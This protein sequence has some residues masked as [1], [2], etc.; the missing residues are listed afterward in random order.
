MKGTSNIFL[1][2]IFIKNSIERDLILVAILHQ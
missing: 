2:F 1:F